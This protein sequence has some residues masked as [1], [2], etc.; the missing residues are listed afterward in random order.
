MTDWGVGI[1]ELA[2][3]FLIVFLVYLLQCICWVSPHA[4]VFKLGIRAR[5]NRRYQGFVWNALDTAGL[6]ANPFPPLAPLLATQWPAFELSPDSI[7]FPGKEGERVSI[8]WEKLA[9]THSDSKLFCNGALAFKGSDVQVKQCSEILTQLKRS[10]RGQREQIIQDWLRKMINS[11]AASR[12]VRVFAGRACWLRVIANF[13]F[14]FLFLL[15]PLGFREFGTGILWRAV[16]MLVLIDITIVLEFWTLHK[17]MFPQAESKDHRFKSALTIL[18]SPIAAIRA[19]DAVARDLLAGYHPLAAAGA[20]LSAEEFRRFAGEQLRLCRFGDYANKQ[21]QA[22]LQK[23][24]EK[25]IRQQDLDPE[26]LMRPPEAQ[27][28]CVVYCPRCLAQY[29]K[30]REECS[31]CGFENI[32]QLE[33]VAAGKSS[34]K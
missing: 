4:I 9:V 32:A 2:S 26:E 10:H 22:M 11:Q 24:M 23:A 29:T 33:G 3:L 28:G 5:G 20:L 17:V 1:T 16:L 14:V 8:S 25:A 30:I 34:S 31:D 19:C 7:R 6:L 13:Q 15:I 12:L 18:L 27:S 21:Y